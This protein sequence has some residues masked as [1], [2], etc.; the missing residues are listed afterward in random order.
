MFSS[1][2][3]L[4]PDTHPIRLFYHKMTALFAALYYWFPADKM[5]VVGVTGTNGKTTTVNLITNILNTA[6]EKVGMMSTALFQIGEERW[7]NVSKQTT[8][9]PFVMQKM[10]RRMLKAGCKYAIV[11]VSS[12]AMTQSRVL[13]VN[14]DVAVITNIT[15]DHIEYHG[16]FN[17]YLT[18]KGELFKK[19][20]KSK[21]KPEVPKVLVLNSD[22]KYYGYF[23]QFV[24]DM[25]MTYG[26]KGS[27][28]YAAEI[29]K[30][31][32]GSSFVMHVPNNAV[33]IELRLPGEF[34]IYNS[35]A[36]ATVAIT[37][38]IPLETIKKGLEASRAI[39]GRFEHVEVG[40]KYSVIVDYAHATDALEHLLLL[41]R[42]LTPGR[43]FVVFGA[44]GGGRDKAKRPK[45]GEVAHKIADYI[46]L[47]DDDPYSED[48]WEI[49]EQV[50]KGIPRNEGENFWKIP[51]R[52]EAIRLALTL[53]KEGDCVIVA[54]KGCEEVMMVRGKKIK[55][56]DKQVIKGLLE[57]DV[58]IEIDG[59]KVAAENVCMKS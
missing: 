31:P 1:L 29:K 10:L 37:L 6:G 27:T 17:S 19:V 13:G 24:A 30:R 42:E 33:D 9:S 25:K 57:R 56:N 12:H 5:I 26:L 50:A 2:K 53:A 48:E 36:A 52:K 23:N 51:D 40:Q 44:T 34:N 35:L 16:S 7:S 54:G 28:V 14:I 45:M 15:E 32:G 46:V 11:E 38:Q 59:K 47:T 4:F 8:M 55:W 21:R 22:D 49:I 43:L 18:A 58:V 3:K 20:S 39:P 41:Y